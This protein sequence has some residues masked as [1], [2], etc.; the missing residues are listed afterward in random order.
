MN[1]DDFY[2]LG[3]ILKTHGNKGQVVVLLD[4]DDPEK[5]QTLELVYLALHGERVPFFID[6]LELKHNRKAIIRFQ[7]FTTIEDA[8]CLSGLEMYLPATTLPALKG[9]KFYYHEIIG[10][11]VV[12][13]KHGD[14]GIID[15]ILE[16]PSQSLLQIRHGEKEILIPIVDDIIRKVDRKKRQLLIDAPEGLIEIYI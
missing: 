1:K 3:K 12:D 6:S 11:A 5:Y 15:D 14:I 9:K 8:T 2:Y 13:K 10:Y 16:M 4:V 7:D